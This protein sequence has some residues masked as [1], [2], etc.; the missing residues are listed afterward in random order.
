MIKIF[1]DHLLFF[2][3]FIDNSWFLDDFDSTLESI[4]LYC[5]IERWS[6]IRERG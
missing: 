4:D 1:Y 3:V 5:I 6:E 2:H